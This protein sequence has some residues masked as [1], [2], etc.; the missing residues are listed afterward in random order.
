LLKTREAGDD[1]IRTPDEL[2]PERLRDHA[3]GLGFGLH[4]RILV[5]PALGDRGGVGEGP[6]PR[7]FWPTNARATSLP[8]PMSNV[9]AFPSVGRGGLGNM[10]F[11]WA[12]A[13]VFRKRHGVPML[14]PQWTQFKIGP[15]LRGE[16]DK[17]YYTGLFDHS[18]SKYVSG[19]V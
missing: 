12:R 10:L 8:S 6:E 7:I 5:G 15:L 13:E 14:A 3:G 16:R 4:A 19:P 11:P 2:G 17:R 9:F 1:Q 18:R